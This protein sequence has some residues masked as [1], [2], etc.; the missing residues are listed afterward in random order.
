MCLRPNGTSGLELCWFGQCAPSR[1]HS[2]LAAAAAAGA[3][4]ELE[5]H[6]CGVCSDVPLL[7]EGTLTSKRRYAGDAPRGFLVAGALVAGEA[8][9]QVTPPRVERLSDPLPP[10]RQRASLKTV[11]LLV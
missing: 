4:L 5:D 2:G 3:V 7:A 9:R 8:R 10:R 1:S 6:P 11:V